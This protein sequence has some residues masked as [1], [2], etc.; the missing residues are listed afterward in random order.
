[1]SQGWM[2]ISTI[3]LPAAILGAMLF[4]AA[5]VTPTVFTALP[6]EQASLYLRALFPRYYL[7][8]GLV[9]AAAALLALTTENAIAVALLAGCAAIFLFGRFVA[10]PAINAARDGRNAGDAK[11]ERAFKA[12]HRAMVIANLAQM[13]VLAY[14]L[15]LAV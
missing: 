1:M 7:A 14:L 13:I 9:S 10:V 8:L 15:F 5:I 3:A 6:A 11:G 12:W 4:F 2:E